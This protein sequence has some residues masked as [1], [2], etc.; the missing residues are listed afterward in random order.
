MKTFI[1][2]W[3]TNYGLDVIV[4]NTFTKEDAE[5]IAKEKGAWEGY[6]ITE[7]DRTKEGILFFEGS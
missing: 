7:V 6:E 1:I 2:N 5:N 4:V 3:T